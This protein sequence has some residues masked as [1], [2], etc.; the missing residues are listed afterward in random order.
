MAGGTR[1]RWAATSFWRSEMAFCNEAGQPLVQY[2]PE[3][4]L[5]LA[6]AKVEVTPAGAAVSELSLLT[7]LGWYLM[8]LLA[9]DTI[10]TSVLASMI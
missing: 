7:V 4:L 5:Q 9:E 3:R 10:T 2:K 6:A 1:Y 8:L